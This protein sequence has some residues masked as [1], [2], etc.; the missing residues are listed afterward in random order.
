M[1]V[2]LYSCKYSMYAGILVCVY[3]QL[4]IH[5]Y[6]SHICVT[7]NKTQQMHEQVHITRY[8]RTFVSTYTYMYVHN[9]CMHACICV[10]MRVCTYAGATA[11]LVNFV[12]VLSQT[13]RDFIF[14][15]SS[16]TRLTRCVNTGSGRVSH[17]HRLDGNSFVKDDGS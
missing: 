4:Y 14:P 7:C 3:V 9:A 17:G 12:S 16:E 6:I 8:L 5:L 15:V 1:Y 10:R 13:E 11:I 2:R